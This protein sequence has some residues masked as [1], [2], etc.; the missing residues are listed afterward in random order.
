MLSKLFSSPLLD[1]LS[2]SSTIIFAK[3]NKNIQ[4]NGLYIIIE[5]KIKIKLS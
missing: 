1:E 2:K 3:K 4:I 5:G